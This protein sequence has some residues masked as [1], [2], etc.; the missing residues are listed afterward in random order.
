MRFLSVFVKNSVHP[1]IEPNLGT[2][3]SEVSERVAA[4][5]KAGVPLMRTTQRV[6]D[7]VTGSPEPVV[8]ISIVTD[9]KYVWSMAVA[10]YVER[11][12][13]SPGEEFIAH[14]EQNRWAIPEL[15]ATEVAACLEFVNAARR[16]T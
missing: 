13:V 10:H 11:H 9:G 5:L 12:H 7:V 4:Y 1:V 15:S 16:P 2:L 8:P 3:G 14:C 6:P